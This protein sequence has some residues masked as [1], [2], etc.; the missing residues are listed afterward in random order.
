[1]SLKKLYGEIAKVE[2]QDDGTIIVE[3]YASAETVDSD[4]E[5]I[6]ADAISAALPDYMKFANIRE[7]HQPKAAGVA[8]S[9]ETEAD[10]RTKLCAHIVDAEAVKKVKAGVYK[11]FSIGGRVTAR[12]ELDKAVITGIKLSEISLVDRPA[13]PDAVITCYKAEDAGK[14]DEAKK[15]DDKTDDKSDSKDKED[16]EAKPDGKK[17]DKDKEEPKDE[18]SEKLA[19]SAY[20]VARVAEVAESV[21]NLHGHL[22]WLATFDEAPKE[23]IAQL[24]ETAKKMYELLPVVAQFESERM[25]AMLG[26][27]SE[28]SEANTDLEK[29]E[30]AGTRNNKSDQA[31]LNQALALLKQLGAVDEEAEPDGDESEKSAKLE[32]L[33]T[34][35]DDLQKRFDVTL[36]ERDT[37]QKRVSE[38]EALPEVPKGVSKVVAKG[39]DVTDPEALLKGFTP[40]IEHDGSLNEAA[41]LMKA[42]HAGKI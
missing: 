33:A 37:L 3:G 4:G 31:T 13:N 40:I 39:E 8:L 16:T 27:N 21:A 15:P 12:D 5:T 2:D 34:E 14:D 28:K 36:A 24:S 30:K 32:K 10:G 42:V 35:H 26:S 7:M 11:G 22:D 9:A 23:A 29:L 20:T 25:I 6:K 41:T 17:S 1:M 19:K 38:L 18:P